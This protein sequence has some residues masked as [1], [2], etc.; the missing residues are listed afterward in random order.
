MN[1]FTEEAL[2][3]LKDLMA[4]EGIAFLFK[5]HIS[6]IYDENSEDPKDCLFFQKGQ[7]ACYVYITSRSTHLNPYDGLPMFCGKAIAWDVELDNE[8][9]DLIYE[10]FSDVTPLGIFVSAAALT[11]G[12]TKRG[13]LAERARIESTY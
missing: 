3:E 11:L 7:M 12:R 8:M 2:Q 5:H 9:K 6:D 1:H 10:E 4:K 13:W